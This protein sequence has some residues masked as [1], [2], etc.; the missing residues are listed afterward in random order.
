MAVERDGSQSDAI[1]DGV[2]FSLQ[3]T[4]YPLSPSGTGRKL[5]DIPPS[6]WDHLNLLTAEQNLRCFVSVFGIDKRASSTPPP[7]CNPQLIGHKKHN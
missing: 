5:G 4:E 2:S 6:S 1:K 3:F 7:P